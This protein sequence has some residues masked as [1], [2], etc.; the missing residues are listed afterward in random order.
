MSTDNQQDRPFWQ[1]LLIYLFFSILIVAVFM[2]R[3][4]KNPGTLLFSSIGFGFLMFVFIA[5]GSG[6][7]NNYLDKKLPWEKGL[8]KR[9]YVSLAI[10]A[11]Y[12]F[13]L[14]AIVTA[15]FA[16]LFWGI[17]WGELSFARIYE[18]IVFTALISMVASLFGFCIYFLNKWK[19]LAEE[20]EQRKNKALYAQIE[21]LQNQIKPHFLFNN[22]NA[23]T[24][25][26]PN[27]PDTAIQFVHQLANVYRYILD[28]QQDE[29]VSLETEIEFAESYVYLLKIRFK[30]K[31][32]VEWD[33][34]STQGMVPP[35]VLQLLL[36]NT[37]KHNI[38]SK[39]KP[40]TINIK[41]TGNELFVVN[42]LQ[43]KQAEGV[44][45]GI[46]LNNIKDR[47]QLL[48]NKEV[49]VDKTHNQFSVKVQILN[50]AV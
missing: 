37:V 12:S 3:F 17:P 11:V 38:I 49:I 44:S 30:D 20:L 14:S 21:T 43:T 4:F 9:L 50:I 13:F 19:E 7:I 31:L 29:L 41:R 47:Y 18:N 5:E 2:P 25:I 26:I 46:G 27:D 33:M 36:E 15:I 35:Y 48:S 8:K 16:N 23:I 32:K 45:W 1:R 28:H 34:D 22:L 40:L 6:Q 42:N 39:H 24:S 10:I